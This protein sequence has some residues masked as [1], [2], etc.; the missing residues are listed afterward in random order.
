[1]KKRHKFE[2]K[3]VSETEK[4]SHTQSGIKVERLKR[5][6]KNTIER[7]R[8]REREGERERERENRDRRT[9][10]QADGQTYSSNPK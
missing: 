3:K 4:E 1:M 5:Q 7:E 2:I 6:K 10:K 8:E 9:N